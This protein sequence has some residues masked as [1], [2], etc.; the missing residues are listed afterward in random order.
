VVTKPTAGIGKPG[1]AAT[2][3]AKVS[4][5]IS[6]IHTLAAL[7]LVEILLPLLLLL[8]VAASFLR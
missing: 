2:G 3:A 8:L 1:T 6:Y 7:P 4:Q 5:C